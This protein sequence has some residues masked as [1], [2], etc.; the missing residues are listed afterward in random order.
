[1]KEIQ[2]YIGTSRQIVRNYIIS[3][4]QIGA[5][6]KSYAGIITI[7]KIFPLKNIKKDYI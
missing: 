1:M 5:R 6:F 4:F 3:E 2:L 7:K